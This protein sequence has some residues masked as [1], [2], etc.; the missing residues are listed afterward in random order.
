MGLINGRDMEY[1]KIFTNMM[2]E[3]FIFIDSNGSI[4]LYNDSAKEIFGLINRS[5]IH[6]ESGKLEK[7][8]IVIIGNNEMGADDGN[9]DEES[10]KLL[11]LE[12][13]DISEGDAFLLISEYKGKNIANIVGK[14]YSEKLKLV[15]DSLQMEIEGSIDFDQQRVS[16]VVEGD[17][18]H[19]DYINAI[20]HMV[21]LDGESKSLKF[22]QTNGYTAR[23]ESIGDLLRGASFKGKGL[24]GE[25]LD[26]IGKNIFEIHRSE[27]I[28]EDFF[29][30]AKGRNIQ[31]RDKYEVINGYPTLCTLNP[32]DEK[33]E[34][35]GAA[36]KVEDISKIE[37]V[38][39]ERDK[40]LKELEDK[41]EEIREKE[42]M[43]KAFPNY[44]GESEK[45]I[46]AKR[47]ALKGSKTLSNILLIGELG[48]GKTLLAKNIHQNSILSE[49]EFNEL[50]GETLDENNIREK[51]EK[52]H[53]G[54]VYI[55][56]IELL[57]LKAQNI[58]LEFI[59]EI[60]NR[61]DI[62][63]IAATN[64]N[65]DKDLMEGKFNEDLYY[66]LNVFPI[67]IPSLR[68]RK[69]D[70]RLIVNSILPSIC[71]R[72]NTQLKRVSSEALE[73]I[74]SYHWP[75]NIRELINVLE[76]GVNLSVGKNILTEH[77]V[78][79]DDIDLVEKEH[80]TLKEQLESREKTIIQNAL[81]LHKGDR[82]KTIEDLGISQSTF[83]E[84][85]KRYNIK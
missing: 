11:G 41:S 68:E 49:R 23:R 13:G 17:K 44:I 73:L 6:H 4:S 2:S 85:L 3:G 57:N 30:V 15:D 22:Y 32:V 31:Y 16:I 62:R 66:K 28:I 79:L 34:R 81:S 70:I 14:K 64:N 84:K 35:I 25:E 65:L 48:V 20:G 21:I 33:G 71:K 40:I 1:A 78:L 47:L 60:A 29:N 39:R 76:R 18:F 46:Q 10:L 45:M 50:I 5:K 53:S 43:E 72:A 9:M 36:L 7:G 12:Q 51:L 82:Q 55:R 54:T 42:N 61:D 24:E 77:I 63:L 19:M 27:S 52:I 59:D 56:E 83:Y 67:R 58:L 80:M 37:R 26:V 74:E 69:T 75:N 8:D 38:I